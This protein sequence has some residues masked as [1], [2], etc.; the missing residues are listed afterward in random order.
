MFVFHAGTEL[1]GEK[2]ITAGGRVL[3]ITATG[4]DYKEAREKVYKSISY[5]NFENM[6]YRKDIGLF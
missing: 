3:G 5:I 1:E 4:K 6:H 2:I